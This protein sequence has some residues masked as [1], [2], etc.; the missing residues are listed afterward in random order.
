M[1][2]DVPPSLPAISPSR[3]DDWPTRIDAAQ[4]PP[5]G[6]DVRQDRGGQRRALNL[7]SVLASSSPS[8]PTPATCPP[9][10]SASPISI[11]RSA[12]TCAMPAPPISSAARPTATRRRSASSPTGGQG[13][14]RGPE[15]GRSQGLTLVV[16]DCYRPGP[17]R[18]RFRRLDE[19]R[20]P[21]R[22]ALVSAGQARRPDR[23]RLYR[24]TLQ[25]FARLDGR[26][27]AR[28]H[29]RQRRHQPARSRLRR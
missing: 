15:A 14:L 6:G 5:C 4:S 25:P 19:E 9:A 12:R 23:R 18:R 8:P 20:R 13:A 27:R 21:A 29:R 10:S 7:A 1:A 26:S 2:H 28:P 24:R 16:F 22:P 3:G 17:R 11:R